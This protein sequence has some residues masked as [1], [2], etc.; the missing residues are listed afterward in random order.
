VRVK[1]YSPS[2]EF[3]GVVAGPEQLVSGQATRIC[4]TVAECQK[5]GFDVAVDSRGKVYILDTINNVIRTF[6]KAKSG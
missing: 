1:I 4:E 5:G 6:V 3:V 2:G